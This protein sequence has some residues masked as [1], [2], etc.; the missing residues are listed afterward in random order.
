MV[1][2]ICHV[3]GKEK[4][5]YV[6]FLKDDIF[7]FLQYEQAREDGAICER[8][9]KYFAMTGEFKDAT[10][11]E[12]E[13]AKESV[14]FARM[15]LKWWEKDEKMSEEKDNQRDWEGTQSIAK[16]F[17][18]TNQKGIVKDFQ[19]KFKEI[20]ADKGEKELGK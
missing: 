9:D 6:V 17:R 14:K 4:K 15:L 20:F 12:F 16:W 1:K 3:C 7:S 18:E 10:E 13:L 19:K 8:C 5:P 2:E 11:E